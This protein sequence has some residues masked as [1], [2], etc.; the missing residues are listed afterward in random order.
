MRNSP[1][2]TAPTRS[3]APSDRTG[4]SPDREGRVGVPCGVCSHERARDMALS[5]ARLGDL[6]RQRVPD[7]GAM[8]MGRGRRSRGLTPAFPPSSANDSAA[9]EARERCANAQCVGVS[10]LPLS[11]EERSAVSMNGRKHGITPTRPSPFDVAH[12]T[13]CFW[14][15]FCWRRLRESKEEQMRS[16]GYQR[17]HR[18]GGLAMRMR[19][20][21]HVL[22]L[23]VLFGAAVACG[24]GDA[25]PTRTET[26]TGTLGVFKEILLGGFSGDVD[27]TLT[28]T[29][30]AQGTHP[31]ARLSFA[32]VS[33]SSG[34][35]QARSAPSATP[36]ITLRG[37]SGSSHVLVDCLNCGEVIARVPYTLT[38]TGR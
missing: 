20:T 16:S 17:H 28:W 34:S 1:R 22:S 29:V 10:A 12:R 13:D 36:P 31:M 26:Y 23:S 38:L 2:I 25:G 24:G 6:E 21:M 32:I 11:S 27:A 4:R 37:G 33:L 35:V 18:V 30:P 9:S 19:A 7:T 5:E 8:R 3:T 14:H 15:C